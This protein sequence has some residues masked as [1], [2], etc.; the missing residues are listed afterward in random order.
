LEANPE[1]SIITIEKDE[2]RYERAVSNI[3]KYD[4]NKKIKIVY[5]DAAD[6]ME[7]D[8]PKTE[9]FDCVFIDAAKGQYKSYFNLADK[10]LK[11]N[12]FLIADNV[13]FRGYVAN[14]SE[15]HAR[16]HRKDV[17]KLK[18]FNQWISNVRCYH[19]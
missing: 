11:K 2:T 18:E 5:G 7:N 13:L 17:K 12:G 16:R 3:K 15:D 8:L 6:V 10:L 14:A 19:T 9:R 4:L 1:S